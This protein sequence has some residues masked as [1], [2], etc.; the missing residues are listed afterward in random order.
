MPLRL[1][2][3]TSG[4]SQLDAPAVAG[5]QT[6][7]LPGTGGTLDRL[8]RA[9]N[10]LQVVQAPKTD[11]ATTISTSFVDIAGLS[12]SIAPATSTNKVLIVLSVGF[13]GTN[14]NDEVLFNFVR[15]ST[16]IA[17]PDSGSVP[18]TTSFYNGGTIYT[19]SPLSMSW[20]DSPATTSSTTY[21]IQWRVTGNT[22]YLNRAPFSSGSTTVS[23]L[24]LLEVAE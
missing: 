1:N 6:F 17:Q 22:G 9:G 10:I 5:D 21:K 3:S 4:Y 12:A 20:L 2:G 11:T 18:K 14:G 13:T 16:A 24:L 8:N 7:T 19:A 15:G 23:S